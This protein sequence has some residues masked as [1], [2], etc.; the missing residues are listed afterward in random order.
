MKSVKHRPSP[1]STFKFGAWLAAQVVMCEL[2]TK[3]RLSGLLLF[4]SESPKKPFV[5]TA[6]CPFYTGL[7]SKSKTHKYPTHGLSNFEIPEPYKTANWQ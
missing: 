4:R 7:S 3:K 1:S 2:R 6:R 5:V